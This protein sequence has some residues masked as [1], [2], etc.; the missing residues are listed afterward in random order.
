[1]NDVLDVA[2]MVAFFALAIGF[3]RVVGRMIDRDADPDRFAD[4]PADASD[5]IG[6]PDTAPGPV[7]GFGGPR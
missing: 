1:M 5:A 7:N 3:V 4:E 2:I 6:R